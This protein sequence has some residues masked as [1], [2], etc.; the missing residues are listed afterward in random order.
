MKC[1]FSVDVEDWFHILD[2]PTTP[3]QSQWDSLPSR[4][5]WNF[6]RLLD[7]FSQQNTRV[8]CFF[9]GW[10]AQRFPHLVRE[11]EARG[12]EVASHGYSHRLVYQ[13]SRE[14]FLQDVVHSRKMLEDIAGRC[15]LGYRS[16]GFS[17]VEETPW[18]FDALLDAGYGYDSSVF[19]AVRGHGGMTNSPLAPY[20]VADDRQGM[21]EFP[22]SVVKILGRPV[23]LFGG[24][25][26]RLFP[27]AAIKRMARR[28]MGEG[29]PVI[30]YVHPR[31]IDPLHPRLPMSFD[32]RFKC[33]VNL[34]TTEY[35]IRS[36]LTEFE[37]TNFREYLKG[38]P[39]HLMIGRERSS[40]VGVP[41]A[42]V[43]KSG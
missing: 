13:M 4:V 10:V 11:A 16:P 41:P 15:V 29:R 35:K 32:R 17:V 5:E 3:P 7:I 37:V 30:F 31:E 25:Y 28:V 24:G 43:T 21:V 18:F 8:T 1:I 40:V 19:P 23:C 27:L 2:L 34:K 12:H 39:P 9:L 33:Y 14:E 6:R 36:L 26:L 22:I 38:A 20:R 42:G